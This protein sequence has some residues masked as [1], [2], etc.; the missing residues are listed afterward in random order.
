MIMVNTIKVIQT[1]ISNDFKSS[2][3]QIFISFVVRK[4]KKDLNELKKQGIFHRKT[5]SLID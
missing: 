5:L 2:S 1:V 3:R 4:K